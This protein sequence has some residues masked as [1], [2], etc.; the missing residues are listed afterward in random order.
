MKKF[1]LLSILVSTFGFVNAQKSQFG[2]KGGLN[3]SNQSNSIKTLDYPQ[4]S[5]PIIAF[6]IGGFVEIKIS[7]NISV[8]P[9]L[10]YSAQGGKSNSVVFLSTEDPGEFFDVESESSLS[11]INI[12]VMF[13]YYVIK[14]FSLDL[15]PQLGVLV[16]SKNKLTSI[17]RT[18]GEIISGEN[19]GDLYKSIDYGLNIGAGYAITKNISAEIRYNLGLNNISKYASSESKNSVFSISACYKF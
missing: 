18:T 13:K 16:S 10:L 3:I 5:S 1:I 17:G 15:G 19:S 12:P 2:I 14:E 7:D 9:E 4:T 6:N 8:Q 11:Y